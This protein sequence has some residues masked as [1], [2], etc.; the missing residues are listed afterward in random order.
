MSRRRALAN[1]LEGLQDVRPVLAAMKN[2]ALA[3]LRKL[4]GLAEHQRR[5]LASIEAA[6]ADFLAFHGES[7]EARPTLAV[8]IA[9][10][11]E[12]GLCGEYNRSIA[13][14]ARAR[15]AAQARVVLVGAKLAERFGDPGTESLPGAGV[16]EELPGIL[17]R[18][19]AWLER[20]Q[21]TAEGALL[22]VGVL[23]EDA[24]SG[25]LQERIVAPLPA[26]P[27]PPAPRRT[28]P[29]LTLEPRAFFA[30]L[31]E[32]A[33]RMALHEAFCSALI[34]EN[35]RRLEQMQGAL[36]RL[37]EAAEDLRRRLN[38]SRQEEITQEI[39]VIMLSVEAL[40]EPA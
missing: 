6:A 32:Q 10:G 27:S 4:A 18:L 28:R 22:S 20:T 1:R 34:A 19:T 30:A 11:S 21:A 33:L 16:A 17:E 29:L 3:E 26:S 8:W 9:I 15:L 36:G 24:R 2:F 13:D 23:Y 7:A 40:E 12:R 38:A 5:A 14:A 31:G 39:E 25:R 35:T 37:D